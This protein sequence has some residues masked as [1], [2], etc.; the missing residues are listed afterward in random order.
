[1]ET[2]RKRVTQRETDNKKRT[3]TYRQ[4]KPES[5]VAI[6]AFLYHKPIRNLIVNVYTCTCVFCIQSNT[7]RVLCCSPSMYTV[8]LHNMSA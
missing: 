8:Y 1:M 5:S 6:A 4:R 7:Q 2:E 3:D